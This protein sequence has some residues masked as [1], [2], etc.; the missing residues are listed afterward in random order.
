MIR[1]KFLALEASF[2]EHRRRLWAG[3]EAKALGDGGQTGVATATGLARNP[4]YAGLREV[5]RLP[6][7]RPGVAQRVRRPGGAASD[8]ASM[9]P[10][11]LPIW[12]RCLT[13]PAEAILRRPGGGPAKV[14]GN[15]PGLCNNQG[16]MEVGKRWRHD[17]PNWAIVCK[18]T[19]RRRKAPPP[20]TE[21]PNLPRSISE[22][23]SFNAVGT[24]GSRGRLSRRP[25]WVI[26]KIEGAHGVARGNRNWYESLMWWISR[27]VKGFPMASTIR[28]PMWGGERRQ[29]S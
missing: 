20:R 10:S 5:D 7:P 4:V 15:S 21:K 24:L 2:D 18:G 14:P 13:R 19:A 6:A 26:A 16:T 9:I 22:C 28:P 1:E 8:C 17:W 25:W 3:T 23:R 29:R 12:T 27:W 11:W